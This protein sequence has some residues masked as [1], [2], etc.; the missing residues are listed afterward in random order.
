V[1]GTSLQRL[2]SRCLS[3][4]L[5]TAWTS[6]TTAS[7]TPR[8]FSG[9]VQ[10]L[11]CRAWFIQHLVHAIQ[12]RRYLELKHRHFIHCICCLSTWAGSAAPVVSASLPVNMVLSG[13]GI[14]T[15]SGISFADSANWTLTSSIL[16]SNACSTTAWTSLTA[17][18]CTPQA[19]KGSGPLLRSNT[20]RGSRDAYSH[21]GHPKLGSLG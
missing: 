6:V 14:I 11:G 21:I 8:S 3:T 15:I 1:D 19:Y 17:V 16:L 9:G 2:R 18:A 10:H 20:E 7:C 12:L 4:C 5:S 13:S